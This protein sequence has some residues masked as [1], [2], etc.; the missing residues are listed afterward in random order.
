[1]FNLLTAMGKQLLTALCAAHRAALVI[2]LHG[3]FSV[4]LGFM[5]FH[6]A[7]FSGLATDHREREDD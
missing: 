3:A 2:A 4:A 5:L 7:L 6:R 1:L